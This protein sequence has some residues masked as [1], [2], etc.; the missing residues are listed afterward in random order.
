ML[1]G[2]AALGAGCGGSREPVETAP[3]PPPSF[4]PPAAGTE[5]SAPATHTVSPGETLTAIARRYGVSVAEL[6]DANEL[7]DPDKLSVGQPLVI[8]P[9]AT[10]GGGGWAWPVAGGEILSPFGAGRGRDVHRGLDIRAR[11]GQSVLAAWPGVVVYSGSGMRDYGKSVILDH[12]GGLTS[13]Y[14]HNSALLVATGDRVERGESIAIAGRSG[15]ATTIH[16]HFEV[17][18]NAVAVD[19]MLYLGIRD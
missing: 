14:A 9:G 12:G 5:P 2:A 11:E 7:P 19:P 8:P 4:P 13:L 17:R 10:G 16:C 6:V 1:V 18:K 3:Q 15:N